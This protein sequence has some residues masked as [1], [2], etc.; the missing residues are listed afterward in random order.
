M[1]LIVTQKT[2][3]LHKYSL[4]LTEL[5]SNWKI[6]LPMI[7]TVIGMSLGCFDG[8]GEGSLFLRLTNYFTSVVLTGESFT[9]VSGFL[10]YLIFP[11]V[12]MIIIFFLGLSVFG[13]VITNLV[14]LC[15]GYTVG[16]ISYFQYSEYTLKGLGYCIIMLY[17]YCVLTL[18][19][20]ILCCRESINMSQLIVGS[21]SKS[22]VPNYSFTSYCRAFAKNLVFIFAASAVKLLL[23]Y[24]FGALFVF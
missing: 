4:K 22:K 19:A 5:L 24:L 1:S 14:P 23:E 16:C 6:V 10:Y 20:I 9:P 7:F 15:Y 17:P 18:L 12:F 11:S 13:S 2:L 3:N 8:K 21:I